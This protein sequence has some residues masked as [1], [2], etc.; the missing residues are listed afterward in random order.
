MVVLLWK[1]SFWSCICVHVC[2]CL[3]GHWLLDSYLDRDAAPGPDEGVPLFSSLSELLRVVQTAAD[4]EPSANWPRPDRSKRN[5]SLGLAGMCC[6]QGCTKN[7]IGRLCW[8]SLMMMMMKDSHW[9]VRS[10]PLLSFVFISF[11]LINKR[12]RLDCNF[13]VLL[14]MIHEYT[15]IS[16]WIKANAM[17]AMILLCC[18][19]VKPPRYSINQNKQFFCCEWKCFIVNVYQNWSGSSDENMVYNKAINC[20]RSLNA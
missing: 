5:F 16:K 15:R 11:D 10:V 17:R 12:Q 1:L 3:G 13:H 6:N 2:V 4:G 20:A 14:P 18:T 9:T 19:A 8:E 7:D